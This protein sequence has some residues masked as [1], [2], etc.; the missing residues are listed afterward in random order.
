MPKVISA[1]LAR[2][3]YGL[4]TLHEQ[5]DNGEL[6]FRLKH[7]GGSA[8]IRTEASQ[9]SGWQNSHY[10]AQVRETYIVES[11][12]MALAELIGGETR[13]RLFDAGDLVTTSPKVVHNVYLS[14]AAVI[15]TVKHDGGAFED[16]LNDGDCPA[17]DLATQRLSNDAEVRAAAMS[18]RKTV[19]YSE[20]YRHFDT[21]IW[22]V[23]AWST[24][25]FAISCQLL[26]D[27]FGTPEKHALLTDWA[28]YLLG[29]LSLSLF[30]FAQ[31]LYRFRSHQRAMKGF[32]N[33]PL[34]KSASTWT[35]SLIVLQSAVLL[36]ACLIA[37]RMLPYLAVS[38]ALI[39]ALATICIFEQSVR[40]A[41]VNPR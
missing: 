29:F 18:V 4:S 23:P 26:L 39:A 8:Y 33:T 41:W 3:R 10:H 22:Q 11:G 17:F 14:D 30:V 37:F 1:K 6:R 2:D 40:N 7:S 20:G 38:I 25:I 9:A 36:G 19:S 5:M 15:H 31:V 13:I 35:Q 34:W 24:A 27:R 21:L 16:R 32:S 28:G 12:W